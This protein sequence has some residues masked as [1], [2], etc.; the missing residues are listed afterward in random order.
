MGNRSAELARS[1]LR[2]TLARL[3]AIDDS[4]TV[5]IGVQEGEGW[6]LGSELKDAPG[7][8]ALQTTLE[9]FA[10]DGVRERRVQTAWFVQGYA[11]LVSAPAVACL[12]SEELV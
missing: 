6:I 11:W 12:L 9:S 1:P 8:Q 10:R 7:Q 5:T 3:A 4:L 2:A